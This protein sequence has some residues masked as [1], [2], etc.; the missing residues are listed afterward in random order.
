MMRFRQRIGKLEV[1]RFKDE[2]A[3]NE[4]DRRTRVYSSGKKNEGLES[5]DKS[6]EF[7]I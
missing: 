5:F 6:Q 7:D 1:I 4:T 2:E 3:N